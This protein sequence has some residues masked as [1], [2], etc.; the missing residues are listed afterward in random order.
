MST[1]V[2]YYMQW[3]GPEAEACCFPSILY[4]AVPY[5]IPRRTR[6]TLFLAIALATPSTTTICYASVMR[7][8]SYYV[9]LFAR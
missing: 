2:L 1:V 5:P 8:E 6:N 3:V 9:V 4:T 7:E